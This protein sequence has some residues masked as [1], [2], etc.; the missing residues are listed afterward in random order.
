[1]KIKKDS[2]NLPLQGKV[3]LQH[4]RQ[5]FLQEQLRDKSRQRL[6]ERTPP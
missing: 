1:M 3:P 2:T 5:M 4:L 6:L